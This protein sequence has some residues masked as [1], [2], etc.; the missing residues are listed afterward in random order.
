MNTAI[1]RSFRQMLASSL[2][3]S[4]AVPATSSRPTA[5]TKPQKACPRMHHSRP[6]VARAV[7]RRLMPSIRKAAIRAVLAIAMLV[8]H[9]R[10]SLLGLVAVERRRVVRLSRLRPRRRPVGHSRWTGSQ[11]MAAT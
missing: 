2:R 11:P 5:S 3:P 10:R 6:P 9:L 7:L 4:K 1:L 8:P